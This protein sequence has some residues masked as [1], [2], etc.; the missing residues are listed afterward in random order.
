[1]DRKNHELAEKLAACQIACNYCFNACLNEEHMHMMVE[2]IKTDKACAEICGT[3]LSLVASESKF[4]KDFVALCADVCNKCADVCVK[5]PADHC[6]ECA[7]A[8]RE[9]A[10]ACEF[11]LN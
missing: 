9:C 6:Q 7:R 8:C 4:A 1:M 2:C 5:H 11:F 3:T 10:E